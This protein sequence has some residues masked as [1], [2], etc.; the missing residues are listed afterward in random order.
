MTYYSRGHE[1]N[2]ISVGDNFNCIAAGTGM[3]CLPHS[4]LPISRGH[5]LHDW[6]A[7]VLCLRS[8]NHFFLEEVNKIR[9][10]GQWLHTPQESLYIRKLSFEEREKTLGRWH[11]DTPDYRY[12]IREGVRLHM[13]CSEA[14]CGD[15]SMELT[16]ANQ[17]DATPWEIAADGEGEGGLPG[18]GGFGQLGI[19][20]RKPSRPDAPECRSKSCSDK[21]AQK[22]MTS[23]LNALASCLISPERAY[24]ETFTVPE[25]Q[26]V[27]EAWTRCFSEKGRL[28]GL[29]DVES[30][31]GYAFRPFKALTTRKE[32]QYS[33]RSLGP[34]EEQ[35]K[36]S[37]IAMAW[38]PHHDETI[39]G[40][41]LQ[42]CKLGNPVK[43]E[44]ASKTSRWKMW[45][46]ME[47]DRTNGEVRTSRDY[48]YLKSKKRLAARRAAKLAMRSVM[49][50]GKEWI[51]N[52]GDESWPKNL[53]ATLDKKGPA[54]LRVADDSEDSDAVTDEA[55]EQAMIQEN[56]ARNMKESPPSYS[57]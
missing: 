38:S 11:R 22:Q 45:Q 54:E 13:Y 36:P 51:A 21:L 43:D 46:T 3:K 17:E 57:S 4:K 44:A 47:A 55:V 33:R 28:K 20:R 37:N 30:K 19:V 7:E 53:K 9:G 10:E 15:A 2:T 31:G 49:M 14:P 27:H 42:G 29:K 35:P 50:Q 1:I 23:V 40:G 34:N 12:T 8:L 56:V 6:H 5:V 41:I 32:F 26:Y 16:M 24:L 48:A 25:S 18:R 39:I 52:T